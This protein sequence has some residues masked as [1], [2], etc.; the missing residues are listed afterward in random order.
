MAGEN[1]GA[2]GRI[3]PFFMS[4]LSKAPVLGQRRQ[5]EM[6]QAAKSHAF[7]ET[8]EGSLQAHFFVPPD[9]K[10]GER[11]PTIVFFHG[12]FWE[13]AM[14]TQFVPHCL[15]F[16][17]RG[18][19]GVAVETRVQSVHGTGPVEAIEDARRFFS[20]LKEHGAAVGAADDRIVLGGASGGAFVALNLVMPK[21]GRDED[22]RP[23]PVAGLA[24]FSSLLSTEGP[25]AAR[26]PDAR[27]ARKLSPLRQ[28]RRKL[29]PM[30]LCHGKNDRI[31]PFEDA[32][33]FTRAMKWRRN[34]IEL[35]DFQNADHS[36][37]NFNVSELHYELTVKA[38]DRFVVDLGLLPPDELADM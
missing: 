8:P 27:T 20:W 31:T 5:R 4:L 32:K 9:L 12:G 10:P 18:A 1:G 17:S 26:F 21:A 22:D 7:A 30:L 38:A 28:L 37:F 3:D 33:R 15:H 2:A 19:V 23:L 36:F 34:R 14:P 16:A 24:L 6:L 29:P 25:L 13:T 11:R 35:L